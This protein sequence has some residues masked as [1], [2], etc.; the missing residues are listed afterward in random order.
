M[1]FQ[2]SMIMFHVNLQ[3]CSS[4][5]P[6]LW[7]LLSPWWNSWRFWGRLLKPPPKNPCPLPSTSTS[8][9]VSKVELFLHWGPSRMHGFPWFFL[10]LCSLEWWDFPTGIFLVLFFGE[11]HK[12]NGSFTLK[13]RAN[14]W[15]MEIGSRFNNLWTN[16]TDTPIISYHHRWRVTHLL[17]PETC[18]MERCSWICILGFPK[19]SDDC[20][21]NGR[22]HC[23]GVILISW[24]PLIN[25]HS[26][27]K[28]PFSIG[29]TSS[30]GGFPSQLC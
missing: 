7:W 13:V 11:L 9:V 14:C 1:I 19:T 17:P 24:Y 28:P 16:K 8:E 3:G 5:I 25:Q 26:N 29:D 22:I 20:L 23:Q 21:V 30:N 4:S 12:K 2:T 6:H 27:G 18:A 15:L 10:N